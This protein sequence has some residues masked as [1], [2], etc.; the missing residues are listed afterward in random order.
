MV[1][2]YLKDC[3]Q[4]K[5]SLLGEGV[6]DYETTLKYTKYVTSLTDDSFS[7]DVSLG[8]VN[9]KILPEHNIIGF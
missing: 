2:E 5:I 3:I 4:M 7:G 6:K 8:L 1:A 9:T